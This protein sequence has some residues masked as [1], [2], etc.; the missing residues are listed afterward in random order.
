MII[1]DLSNINQILL[2][3]ASFNT[4]QVDSHLYHISESKSIIKSNEVVITPDNIVIGY[5]KINDVLSLLFSKTTQN[6][7]DLD[8]I[9][10]AISKTCQINIHN[11]LL[12]N[13]E[14]SCCLQ[15][16][17]VFITFNE[18][19]IEVTYQDNDYI[20]GYKTYK[21]IYNKVLYPRLK[22]DVKKMI[23]FEMNNIDDLTDD[24][25]MLCQAVKI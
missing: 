24:H 13:L 15:Y 23:G 19:N 6:K 2:S 22:S 3:Q 16:D 8:F 21:G 11:L 12:Y 4:S 18:D 17:D 1:P 9:I 25:I 14:P 5:N 7:K 10:R 20:E